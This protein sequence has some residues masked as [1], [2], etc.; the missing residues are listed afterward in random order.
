M[1]NTIYRRNQF[2]NEES[3]ARNRY[4]E[5]IYRNVKR[6]RAYNFNPL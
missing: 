1:S 4:G 2:D 6:S 5:D 3:Y